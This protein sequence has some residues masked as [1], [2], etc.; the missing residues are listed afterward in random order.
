MSIV[1]VS[2]TG[3]ECFWRSRGFVPSLTDDAQLWA[4]ARTQV[5]RKD[6][7][8]V[9]LLG[10]SRMQLGLNVGEFA[11]ST[12]IRPVQLA[13][14]GE[15][16]IVPLRSLVDDPSFSGVIICEL[17]EDWMSPETVG[18]KAAEWIQVYEHQTW[19]SRL[20]QWLGRLTQDTFVFRLPDL[21]PLRVWHH[22]L[23]GTAPT[24]SY[25]KV[26]PDRSILA[27]YTKLD[28]ADQ[29]RHREE[30]VRESYA[31]QP[32][33]P[34]AEFRE[35][36]HELGELIE[37][38]RARGGAVIFVRFPTSGTL[39]ELQNQRY[40]RAQYWDVLGPETGAFTIHF[41]DYPELA[42]FE[43]PDGSH[44]DYRDA[45]PFTHALGGLVVDHLRAK[46]SER[47]RSARAQS[48]AAAL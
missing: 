3:W 29:R 10:T 39:W 9:V 17:S 46:A 16:P 2:V 1:V 32:P 43:C 24:P 31:R 42:R 6:K 4:A 26:L 44:L 41:K 14:N 28:A 37:P 25:V 27:D 35:R 33:W 21:A 20:E 45:V 12:G 47:S 5:G 34:P 19:S 48:G 36:A 23:E 18:G 38:L 40:P 7:D 8:A 11:R 22:L 13:M 15:L 30:V